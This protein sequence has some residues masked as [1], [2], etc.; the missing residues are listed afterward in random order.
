MNM[1]DTE[2]VKRYSGF[3]F[4]LILALLFFFPGNIFGVANAADAYFEGYLGDVVD[5]HGVSY[6]G[7]E[8]YL[9]LTG[10]NLPANGVTLSDVTQRADEGHFTIVPLDSNQQWLYKWNTQ[11]LQNQLEPGTYTIYVTTEPVDLANLGGSNTYKTLEVYLQDTHAPQ[12]ESGPGT[13]TLNPEKHTSTAMPTIVMGQPNASS[14]SIP[15]ES[16]QTMVTATQLPISTSS[17]EVSPPPFTTQAGL[18]PIT[19]FL[20]IVV[21]LCLIF[22]RK[23][24]S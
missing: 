24:R 4:V 9:F 16:S 10:L 3:A 13:Y 22:S 7:N 20:A 18:L 15:M 21:I 19:P 14:A 6:T 2:S 23:D 8:V 1:T 17:L 11:R 12:G 5:I